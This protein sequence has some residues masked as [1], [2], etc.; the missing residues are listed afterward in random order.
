MSAREASIIS[1]IMHDAYKGI[2]ID[3]TQHAMGVDQWNAKESGASDY[4]HLTL[5]TK[6]WRRF[7]NG[8]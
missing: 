2:P 1:R 8:Q 3:L 4:S 7:K 5:G 6:N